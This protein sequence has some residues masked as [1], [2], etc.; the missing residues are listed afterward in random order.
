MTSAAGTRRK[1]LRGPGC[2]R[3]GPCWPDGPWFTQ[4]HEPPGPQEAGGSKMRDLGSVKSS[5]RIFGA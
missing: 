4:T 5:A 1:C 2:W 3:L